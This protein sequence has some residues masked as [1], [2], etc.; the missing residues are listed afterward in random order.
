MRIGELAARSGVPATTI[1]YYESVGL[2][3]A[4]ERSA[5][6]QR[7]YATTALSRLLLVKRLRLLGVGLPELRALVDFASASSCSPV[8][9][10]LVPVV[11]RRLLD[12]DRQLADLTALRAE[13]LRY[14]TTLQATLGRD[15]APGEPFCDCD[16]ATCGCLGDN[17]A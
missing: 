2:L 11:E 3:A 10:R 17:H 14:H 5:S 13:L 15:D 16:P 6:G 8:R 1:R 12:L 4:P 7:S 9:A